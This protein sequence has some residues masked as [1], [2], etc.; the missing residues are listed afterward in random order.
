MMRML[1]MNTDAPFYC[2]GTKPNPV[3]INGFKRI[4]TKTIEL[5]ILLHE[6]DSAVILV[7]ASAGIAKRSQSHGVLAVLPLCRAPISAW[8]GSYGSIHA[9]RV[10][11]PPA[12]RDVA[13]C[14]PRVHPRLF[15]V[16]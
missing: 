5:I 4:M 15:M 16:N 8:R 3:P 13:A 10:D 2:F 1:K 14:G 12:Y 11:Q 6:A 7:V 9:P